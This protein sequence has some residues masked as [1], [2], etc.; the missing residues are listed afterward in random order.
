MLWVFLAAILLF[1]AVL[2][3]R[4]LRFVP[5]KTAP[6]VSTPAEIDEEKVIDD[7]RAM[8]R[9]KTVSY[10]DDSLIDEAEF[11][12]FRALLKERFPKMHERCT[13]ERIGKSGLLEYIGNGNNY[14][15]KY[16]Y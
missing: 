11:D 1:A 4:T 12:K 2:L 7:F 14:I 9:C 5:E 10:S 8:I 15:A 13:L 16:F 6:V 3:V